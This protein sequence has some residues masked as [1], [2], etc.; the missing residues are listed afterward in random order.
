MLRMG[1]SPKVEPAQTGNEHT[2][3][4]PA[5]SY[6]APRTYPTYQNTAEPASSL[7]PQSDTATTTRAVSES[8]SLA[9]NIK[10][11][12]LS[13]YVGNGTVLKGDAS[14][15]AMLRVDGHLSGQVTSESGTLL[16]GTNGVVDANVNVAVAT[17]HGTINGDIIATQRLE[18][19]RTARVNGNIQAPSLMIEQGAIFEGS[20]R[21]VELKAAQDKSK[22]REE[23]A[24]N[25]DDAISSM[26]VVNASEP[27]DLSAMPDMA[28]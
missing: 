24:A 15:K 8:E 1:K 9:R 3:D 12:T 5:P 17:I 22:K 23:R 28:S 20:C 25:T 11:G 2:T 14:F 4:N 21:M 27:A 18:L 13:G 6:N 19:G 26:P 10:E 16:V 7:Y